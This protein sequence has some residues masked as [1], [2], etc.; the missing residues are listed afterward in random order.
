MSKPAV[1]TALLLT[2]LV[3]GGAG[4]WLGTS[5]EPA[6]P[7][8]ASRSATTVPEGFAPPGLEGEV[9]DVLLMPDFLERTAALAALLDRLG[10]ESLEAVRAAY[11]SVLLDLGDT[12]LVLFGEWW[13]R[14]DPVTA[15]KWTNHNW[16]TRGSMPVISA[17]M[18]AWGRTDPQAAIGAASAARNNAVRRRWVDQALRGWDESVQDG[19]L[20]YAK[21]LS[22]GPDRQWALYVVTR[23]MVLRDGPAAAIAWAESLPDDDEAFK[24][25]AFRRVAGAAAEVDPE[26]ARAF[27]ERHLAGPY[28]KGL[29]RRVGMHWVE[30]DGDAAM[31]WLESLPPGK[32]RDDG[33]LETFRHWMIVDRPAARSWMQQTPHEPWLDPAVSIYA[34]AL[35]R[36]D[37]LAA[38]EVAAVIRDPEIRLPAMGA[39]AR[40]WLVR[41]EAAAD[42]WLDASDL[43][44]DFIARIR[45]IPP[46][47]REAIEESAADAPAQ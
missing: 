44:P 29:A 2:A 33:V 18:R 14:F 4:Y 38:L 47:L 39:I 11:D 46:G 21:S 10:P 7:A 36:K 28:G 1:W 19:A 24:L 42:A 30:R 41:D 31:R 37:P 40:E 45:T 32:E 27:A 20:A 26:L 17:I 5:E 35:G 3:A 15:F 8:P 16:S 43:P 23:R 6:E 25:N 12:E 9:R 22:P 13:G 34:K